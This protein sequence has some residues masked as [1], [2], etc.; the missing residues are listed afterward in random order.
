MTPEQEDSILQALRPLC[1]KQEPEQLRTIIRQ[2]VAMIPQGADANEL[3][4]ELLQRFPS[5][6]TV[7]KRPE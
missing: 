4:K 5:L 3:E 2:A 7:L 1:P 6:A